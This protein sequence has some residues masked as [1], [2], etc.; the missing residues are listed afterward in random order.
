[1]TVSSTTNKSG[2]YLGNGS[3]VEFDYEFRILDPSHLTVV[4]TEDGVDTTVSPS[5][6]TVS[7]VG[8]SG[9]GALTFLVAP[10]TGQS[11]TIIRNAPFTQ[12]TDLENQGAYYAETV[13]GALDLG[14]MRDQ[15]LAEGLSRAVQ[16]PIGA[17]P[18]ELGGLI[19]DIIRLS[20]SAGEIDT[21]AGIAAQV[22][23]VAGI[24]ANVTT[25]AGIAA[26]VT[27]VAN[28]AADVTAVADIAADVTVA[29]NNIAAI[30]AAPDH[31]AAAIAAEE[32]AEAAQAAAEA[33]AASVDHITVSSRSLLKA[34]DTSTHSTVYLT[35]TGREGIFV[36][37]AGDYSAQITADPLEGIYVKADAVAATAGAWVRQAGYH[38]S[39]LDIRWFGAVPQGNPSD[40]TTAIQRAMNLAATV[41]VGR[42]RVPRGEWRLGKTTTETYLTSAMPVGQQD[43][44]AL[45]IPSGVVLEGDGY[46][47]RL[48]RY[49]AATLVVVLCAETVGSVVRNLTID[50][51][52][53][54]FPYVGDTYGSGAGMFVESM[55]GTED[56]MNTLD[57]LWIEDTPGYGI[58]VEWG[59]H[60]GLTIQNIAIDG[61]GSDGIDIKRMNSGVFDAKAIVLNAI[62]VTN[63]GKTA[64]DVASQAGVDIRGWVTATNLHVYGAWGAQASSGIRIHDTGG[65]VIGGHHA[66]VNNFFIERTSGGV[67][68][69][70]G[71][72]QQRR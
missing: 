32:G 38:V 64:T 68:T 41:S 69:T 37:R 52:A 45:K 13:E 35:E 18:S 36:W 10:M 3:T 62:K 42:V 63:F 6:Y 51:N 48:K 59:N 66:S 19:E 17:D 31:A 23:T 40:T 14:V 60:R 29:A 8:A 15:Q 12:P 7:G 46:L 25:V 34:V 26:N 27:T 71:G 50:G 24:S 9:G 58:G 20:D 2:P 21:V 44:Y 47:T 61:T 4:M 5:D 22:S 39:G 16:I 11:I 28:I 43:Q 72:A 33:A 1:M 65:G 67:T 56:K 70:Y 55:S 54:S 49:V 53:T 30:I 57:T